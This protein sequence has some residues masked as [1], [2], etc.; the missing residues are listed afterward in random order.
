MKINPIQDGEFKQAETQA[1]DDLNKIKD[2]DTITLNRK[3][4]LKQSHDTTFY[5]V[6]YN[7][8]WFVMKV[9]KEKI[10]NENIKEIKAELE[11]DDLLNDDIKTYIWDKLNEE[12]HSDTILILTKSELKKLKNE[13]SEV[14]K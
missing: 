11:T 9:F 8:L 3:E 2:G 4:H 6:V 5:S 7:P 10:S 13:I 14:L 12:N 1:K